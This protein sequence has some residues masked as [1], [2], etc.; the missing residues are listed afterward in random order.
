MNRIERTD[1]D[2]VDVTLLRSAAS[3]PCAAQE[4]EEREREEEIDRG[5]MVTY[6]QHS[7]T[8]SRVLLR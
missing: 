1:G 8:S 4:E 3:M 7:I 6:Q 2:G 5:T